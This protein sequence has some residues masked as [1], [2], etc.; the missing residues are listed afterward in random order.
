MGMIDFFHH[1]PV[2][3]AELARERLRVV[4]RLDRSTRSS[5]ECLV[6]LKSELIAVIKKYT[7]P[8]DDDGDDFDDCLVSPSGPSP[9]NTGGAS[10]DAMLKQAA[11]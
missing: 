11:H 2:P 1:R 8:N 9:R 4:I 6:S 7:N 3:S 10:A 5:P